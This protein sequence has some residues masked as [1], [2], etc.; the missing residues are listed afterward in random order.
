ML[1]AVILESVMSAAS[2]MNFLRREAYSRAQCTYSTVL[3]LSDNFPSG[4]SLTN[5]CK[6]LGISK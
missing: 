2:M 3:Q 4:Y 1:V 5:S 6:F